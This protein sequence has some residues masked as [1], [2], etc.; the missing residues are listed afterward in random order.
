MTEL[1]LNFVNMSISAGWIVLAVIILR[2]LLK[3]AP[4][5]INCVLWALVAIRLLVPFDIEGIDK[6][7]LTKE[8]KNKLC[9]S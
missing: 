4:K 8:E 6:R 1:F 2:L 9:N 5:W 7:L 3:K